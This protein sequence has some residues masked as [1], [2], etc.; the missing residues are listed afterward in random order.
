M[1]TAEN[2]PILSEH[3][4]AISDQLDIE[5]A[6]ANQSLILLQSCRDV[7]ENENQRDRVLSIWIKLKSA[8]KHSFTKAHF[9]CGMQF[10]QIIG[11]V[12]GA[13]ETLKEMQEARIK[14]P[15]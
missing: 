1:R 11:D 9:V 13:E 10:Y 7:I 3:L 8:K 2:K 14:R 4:D 6:N 5:N 15:P 12:N